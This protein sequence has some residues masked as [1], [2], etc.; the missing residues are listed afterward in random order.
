M[1][2]RVLLTGK[3]HG[4]DI[5]AS[6]VL[7]HTLGS[8]DIVASEIGFVTLEERIKLLKEVE[9]E[10]FNNNQTVLEPAIISQ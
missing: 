6:V 7:L 3:L 10:S 5:G 1:P 9:W 4:P 2:L 8:G